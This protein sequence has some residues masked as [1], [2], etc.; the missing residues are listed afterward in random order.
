MLVWKEF[1]EPT[2][3]ILV[4]LG[5]VLF[6]AFIQS[7]IGAFQ[8]APEPAYSLTAAKAS[9]RLAYPAVHVFPP[10]ASLFGAK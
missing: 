3:L 5:F 1:R 2:G 9:A 6:V 8:A 4:M 10:K 7:G